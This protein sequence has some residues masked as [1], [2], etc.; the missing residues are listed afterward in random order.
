[1]NSTLFDAFWDELQAFFSESTLAVD[2]RRHGDTLHMPYATSLRHLCERLRKRFPE[3]CPPIPS[4]EWIR[5]Q[6]WPCNQYSFSTEICQPSTLP[7]KTFP[8]PVLVCQIF[9]NLLFA[10]K[11][12]CKTYVMRFRRSQ[13]WVMPFVTPWYT[14]KLYLGVIFS[15]RCGIKAWHTCSG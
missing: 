5:L 15:Q 9:L 7:F 14:P 11:T 2:E 1:M 8:L 3:E 4:L 10:T 13:S 6:F 12:P